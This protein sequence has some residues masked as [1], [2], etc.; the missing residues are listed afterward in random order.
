[1]GAGGGGAGGA[2]TSG[3]VVGDAV[4]TVGRGAGADCSVTGAGAVLL[5]AST[6][7]SAMHSTS[8]IHLPLVID[9]CIVTDP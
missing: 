7:H 2:F 9:V 8:E 5:H 4:S 3:L 1:M 6:G